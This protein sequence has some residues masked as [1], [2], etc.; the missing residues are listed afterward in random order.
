MNRVS[1]SEAE[2]Y[3]TC[4]RKHYYGDVLNLRKRGGMVALNRGTLGHLV[5]EVYWKGR[6]AGMSHEIAGLAANAKLIEEYMNASEDYAADVARCFKAFMQVNPFPDVKVLAVEEQY[7]IDIDQDIEY[8]FTI[9]LLIELPDGRVFL[10]DNKFVY[11]FYSDTEVEMLAQL[12][13]YMGALRRLNIRVD[14]CIYLQFRYRQRK[15]DPYPL[16]SLIVAREFY[17]NEARVQNSFNDQVNIARLVNN[18]KSRSPQ[19][20]EAMAIRTNNSL[21]CSRCMFR[22]ICVEELRGSDINL[23]IR[24]GYEP[25]ES[26]YIEEG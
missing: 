26:R 14:G 12:P 19:Q 22:D 23:V 4:R 13:K 21:V 9:D 2:A 20:I 24:S 8:P 17:P 5:M 15:R 25:R 3:L 18:V 7:V 6:Q 16:E 11:D 1:H 10:V